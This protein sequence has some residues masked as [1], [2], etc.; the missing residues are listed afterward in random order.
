MC[1]WVRT[2]RRTHADLPALNEV[3]HAGTYSHK[4]SVRK[5][6]VHLGYVYACEVSHVEASHGAHL[7]FYAKTTLKP[8]KTRVLVPF[9]RK[10][11]NFCAFF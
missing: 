10:N 8:V 4:R 6:R 11:A 2:V 5:T 7:P 9:S 1:A 3:Q